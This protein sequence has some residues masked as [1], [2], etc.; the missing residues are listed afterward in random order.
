MRHGRALFLLLTIVM[1]T[2]N[3]F[4]PVN[5]VTPRKVKAS[6]VI[7]GLNIIANRNNLT[8]STAYVPLF[9]LLDMAT[10]LSLMAV[11]LCGGHGMR[12]DVYGYAV[13]LRML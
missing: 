2:L 8:I 10:V 7:C 11:F 13:L 3:L 4:F 12:V 9:I 1:Y 6:D 5:D